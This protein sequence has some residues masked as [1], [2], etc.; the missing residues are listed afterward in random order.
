MK[1]H[2]LTIFILSVFQP[3]NAQSITLNQLEA[4]FLS[5]NTL[6]LSS[7]YNVEKKEAEI[8][9]EKLWDNPTLTLSEVNL[10]KT[11]HVEE[12]PNLIGKYGKNQQLSVELEQIFVTAGK[13]RKRVAIKELEKNNS[14][15]EYEELLRELK[16]D[17]RQ[18]FMSLARLSKEK[19]Q[20]KN[21]I[22]LFTQMNSQYK[23]QAE[24]KNVP[25]ADYYRLQSALIGLQKN[26]LEIENKEIEYFHRI[27]LLTH[28][29]ELSLADLDFSI[30]DFAP[31]ELPLDFSSTI[32]TDN[33]ELKKISNEIQ[34]S[35]KQFVLEKAQ[36]MPDI[37]FHANYDRGGSIM[38]DFVGIGV[39]LDLPILN[40]NKGNIKLAELTISQQKLSQSAYLHTLN[41][42][43]NQLSEQI[44]RFQTS[45]QNWQDLNNDGQAEMI[46]NY[47]KH[48]QNKQITLLEFI[49]FIQANREAKNAYLE[50][51]EEYQLTREELNYIIGKEI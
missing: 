39:S 8:I 32:L 13:R 5:Q 12:Q 18:S 3:T 1:K 42:T 20:L 9:Q 43:V 47:Q 16:K 4:S 25:K 41:T 44:K 26:E 27:K 45:L 7:K 38:R 29:S 23:R 51:L 33:V 30:F 10:W 28:L 15:F 36:K 50:T 22:S 37:T 31:T 2:V 49:D 48:L 40:N 14:L 35:E 24:I 6:L 11:Y 46:E 21:T 17:L 19:E 34:I